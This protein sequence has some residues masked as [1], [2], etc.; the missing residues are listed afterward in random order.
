MIELF[1]DNDL[2]VARDL[3]EVQSFYVSGSIDGEKKRKYAKQLYDF[4]IRADVKLRAFSISSDVIDL[5][6]PTDE[7]KI[8]HK[9]TGAM[10]IFLE[11]A[12]PPEK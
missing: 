12:V 1:K 3:V 5:P 7:R 10:T 2:K 11:V 8:I 9:Y 4:L 6:H